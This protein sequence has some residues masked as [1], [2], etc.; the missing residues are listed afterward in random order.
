MEYVE[1]LTSN[2]LLAIFLILML[3]CIIR[4]AKR[5]MLMIIYGIVS[6]IFLICFVNF[7]CGVVS[8]YLNVNTPLPTIVQDSIGNHL[9]DKYVTSEEK[10][11]GTGEEAVMK[12][13]PVSIKEKIDETIRSSIEATIQ[14]VS[15]ELSETAIRGI[16]IIISMV[17]GAIVLFLLSKLI[18]LIGYV[19]VVRD[20]NQLLGLAAGFA[21]GLLIIWFCLYLADCFPTSELGGYIIEHTKADPLLLYVYQINIIERIIGI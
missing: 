13:V 16:S 17:A 7:A 5:G 15:K 20:V 18:K 9:M 11:A 6:W 1:R 10:E 21:E 3:F 14:F 12:L 2:P 19:P 4:G 8:D